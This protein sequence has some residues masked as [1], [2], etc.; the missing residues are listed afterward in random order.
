MALF[1]DIRPDPEDPAGEFSRCTY[2]SC[3]YSPSAAHVLAYAKDNALFIRQFS[4]VRNRT[5]GGLEGV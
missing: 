5:R 1:K 2:A 3:G 4:Q